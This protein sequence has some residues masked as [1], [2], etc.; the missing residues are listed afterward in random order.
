MGGRFTRN[1]AEPVRFWYGP[2]GSSKTG[3]ASDFGS[4]DLQV[5]ILSAERFIG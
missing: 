5:R 2:L 1:E 3:N 4:E